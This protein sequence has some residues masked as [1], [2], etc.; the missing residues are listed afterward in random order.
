MKT[1]MIAAALCAGMM[2]AHAQSTP[3]DTKTTPTESTPSATTPQKPVTQVDNKDCLKTSD[4]EWKALGLTAEQMTKVQAIQAEHKK[5]CA[6]M[7]DEAGMK[8]DEAT[9]AAMADK[10]EERIKEVLTPAQNDAWM[11]WCTAQ[12]TPAKPMEKK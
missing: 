10:H 8:H 7:K 9:K 5:D 6:A 1:L 2:S 3:T 4:A 12:A 11:K